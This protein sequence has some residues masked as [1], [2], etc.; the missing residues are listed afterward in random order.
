MTRPSQNGTK[1]E[2]GPP[3]PHHWY[4]FSAPAENATENASSRTAVMRSALRTRLRPHSYLEA[5]FRPLIASSYL[6]W[7]PSRYLFASSP[8]HC[9]GVSRLR[10]M[11]CSCHFLVSVT[12][13][14]V[15]THHF[16]ASG[17]M[18]AGPTTPRICSQ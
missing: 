13:F 14:R 17:D 6:P 18:L 2:P 3:E 16:T 4:C 7:R 10:L 1:A 11:Y 9:V 8:V 5:A 15:S 12:F